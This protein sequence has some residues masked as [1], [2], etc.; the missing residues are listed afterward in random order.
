MLTFPGEVVLHYSSGSPAGT[1]TAVSV[2]PNPVAANGTISISDTALPPGGGWINTVV[3][4]CP[5]I[6]L[7]NVSLGSSGNTYTG[8]AP[9]LLN[10]PAGSYPLYLAATDNNGDITTTNLTLTV[11]SPFTAT[12]ASP[13]PALAN[14]SVTITATLSSQPQALGLLAEPRDG[15]FGAVG[16]IGQPGDEQHVG[17]QLL[18]T[19][20]LP[21]NVAPG[22]YP[23]SIA[24]ADINTNTA[25]ATITLT[26]NAATE[27]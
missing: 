18:L 7:V 22:S 26:V 15:E 25:T 23:L 10:V 12:N 24:V 4:N 19:F 1:N 2:T 11:L 9:V 20:P 16:R 3:A 14:S 17:E 27:T 5:E 21:Y 6:G 13:N 8:S